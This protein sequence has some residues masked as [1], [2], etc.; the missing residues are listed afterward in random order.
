[1]DS[2]VVSVR[3]KKE[4]KRELERDGI[5]VESMVKQ[6]LMERVTRIRFRKTMAKLEKL[7]KIGVK[8]SPAGTAARWVREDRDAGH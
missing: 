4:V 1:M 5:D 6:Y 3:I 8:P 2:V 7:I